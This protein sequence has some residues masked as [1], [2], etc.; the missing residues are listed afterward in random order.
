[1]AEVQIQRVHVRSRPLDGNWDGQNWDAQTDRCSNNFLSFANPPVPP[2]GAETLRWL[3]EGVGDPDSITFNVSVDL[4]SAQGTDY[5]MFQG[6]G[7]DQ[8]TT[9][10]P[11]KIAIP[12]NP[13]DP[14][15]YS[16]GVY[17]STVNGASSDFYVKIVGATQTLG[18]SRIGDVTAA[19]GNITINWQ[20]DAG[21]AAGEVP[22]ITTGTTVGVDE[23]DVR[24]LKVRKFYDDHGNVEAVIAL[25]GRS[26]IV[27]IPRF[28]I[29]RRNQIGDDE[30]DCLKACKNIE[31]LEQRLNCIL[32]CPISKNY[33]VFIA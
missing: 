27:A 22:D 4:R 5:A 30:L 25:D 10:F 19:T 11:P 23:S 2:A 6:V 33:R 20:R 17:I 29:S 15:W 8:V 14:D 13:P 9:Y 1:M 16:R 28:A 3:I 24:G 26:T 32:K 18:G 12:P 7:H 31:D 21:A